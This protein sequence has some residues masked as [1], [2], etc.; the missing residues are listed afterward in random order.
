MN[1]ER[2]KN[3]SSA[4]RSVRVLYI[5]PFHGGSHRQFG[6]ALQR[7][8]SAQWTTLT[9]PGRHWK[10]R[11]QGAA[12]HFMLAHE[13]VLEAPHDLLLASSFLDLASL[14]GLSPALGRVP[15][16]LYF[17]ENQLTYPTHEARPD[18]SYGMTQLVSGLAADRCVFNSRF[19]R[20]SFLEAG[21][22]LLTRLPKPRAPGWM[23]ALATRSEVLEVPVELDAFEAARQPERPPS[24]RREGPLIVWPHR[25]EHDKRPDL[26]FEALDT[27]QAQG[28]RFRVAVLGERAQRWPEVFEAA[29][30]RLGSRVVAWGPA[31]RSDYERFLGTAQIAVSTADQ[32]FFGVSMVEASHAGAFVLVP[33]KLAYPERFPAEHRYAEGALPARLAQLCRDWTSG[34]IDLR[35]NR[36]HLT[37]GLDAPTFTRWAEALRRWSRCSPDL[38]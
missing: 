26:L 2:K 3:P 22:S 23:E 9:L 27:L 35:G 17:H 13:G 20:D 24:A 28:L 30:A 1:D 14:V 34:R 37:E 18:Y 5:E 6:A 21:E 19:N 38:E 10:W 36:T 7:R 16:V 15:K 4:C 29:R 11:M 12:A 25:W 33:D 31:E 32:E 8:V